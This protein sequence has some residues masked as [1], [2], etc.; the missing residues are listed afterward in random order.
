[1]VKKIDNNSQRESTFGGL[2]EASL[3]CKFIFARIF[4]FHVK[5]EEPFKA[6]VMPSEPAAAKRQQ[7]YSD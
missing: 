3:L 5:P 7:N 1:M 4:L 2:E 6:C